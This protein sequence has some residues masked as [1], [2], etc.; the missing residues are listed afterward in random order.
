MNIVILMGRLTR[1]PETRATSNGGNMVTF[2]VAVDRLKRKDGTQNTDFP[3][4]VAFGKTA[5]GIAQYFRKGKPIMVQGR[6]QT[7]QYEVDGEKRTRSEVLV[8]RFEF[9]PAD[10]TERQAAPLPV[11]GPAQ[12]DAAGPWDLDTDNLFF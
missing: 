4:C 10:T 11:T 9:V 8:D 1:D 12:T 7:D 3:R 5:D 2:T 6:Y